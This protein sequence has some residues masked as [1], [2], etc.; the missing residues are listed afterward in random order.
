[1]KKKSVR[2]TSLALLLMPAQ[3]WLSI[4]K[5]RGWGEQT[6]SFGKASGGQKKTNLWGPLINLD[7]DNTSRHSK[8]KHA[9]PYKPKRESGVVCTNAEEGRCPVNKGGH[10]LGT[11]EHRK[12]LKKKKERKNEA[13]KRGENAGNHQ[14]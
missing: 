7:R 2:G 10:V 9:T 6:K 13:Q 1:M 4:A 11:M 5:P 8:K 14:V 12:R 3:A